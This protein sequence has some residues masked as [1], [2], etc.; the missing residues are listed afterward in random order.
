M[1]DIPEKTQ[2]PKQE[3]ETDNASCNVDAKK[4]SPTD[5]QLAKENFANRKVD[6]PTRGNKW[7]SN[8]FFVAVLVLTIVLMYQLSMNAADGQKTFSEIWK[9]IRVEYAVA[10]VLTL[11]TMIVLDTMKYFVIL[12]ATT[13]KFRLLMSL[14]TSLIGKYYDNI[15]PFSSGGQPFQIHYLH[16]KGLTGGESTAVIFIKFCFNILL[17]LAI[18]MC[19]MVFNKD[20]LYTYVTNESQRNW[21][22]VL[23]WVGFALNCSIPLLIIAFAVFP[24]LM[25]TLTRWFLTLGHKMKLIKSKD[26][27]VLR[28]K[29]VASDFRSAFVIM[30]HKPL[31]AICLTVCCLGELFL[32]MMLPYF[33]VVALAGNAVTPS[34][35]LMFAIMTLNVYVSM[36]VTAVPTPGNSGAL[37][38]AFLLILT[39]VAESV[40]FWSVF[41]WRFLSYYTFIIIGVCIFVVDFIRKQRR[42]KQI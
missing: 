41:S 29:R 20:A 23:G 35:D 36:T 5:L 12:H 14:K 31:H 6:E 2:C 21:F 24:K 40:L 38:S 19:L 11:L 42:Q 25:E 39:S 4:K 10:S 18:S 3:T 15:T 16:K 26:A 34:W 7:V 27:I 37:E 1:K 28:A 22:L 17:L 13:G 33:V 8:I 9:N 32:S 30:F